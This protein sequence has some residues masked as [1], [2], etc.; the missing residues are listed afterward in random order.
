MAAS[1][2][3]GGGEEGRGRGLST[4]MVPARQGVEACC[5]HPCWPPELAPW[6]QLSLHT[7]FSRSLAAAMPQL[8]SLT[9][10]HPYRH[11][12]SSCPGSFPDFLCAHTQF[13]QVREREQILTWERQV[14]LSSLHWLSSPALPLEGSLFKSSGTLTD[15]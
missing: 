2:G 5:L 14:Q 12:C 7:K 15:E 6:P 11:P 3:L 4:E 9:N 8:L 13:Q 1:P 10:P